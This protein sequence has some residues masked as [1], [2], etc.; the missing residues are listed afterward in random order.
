VAP[1]SQGRAPRWKTL[2]NDWYDGR[3][4][5]LPDPRYREALQHPPTDIDILERARD[6]KQ[7]LQKRITQG[8]YDRD[9]YIEPAA[10]APGP[11]AAR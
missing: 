6:I 2:I 11:A 8:P 1:A 7:A 10:A 5:A 4:T 9:I 3:S